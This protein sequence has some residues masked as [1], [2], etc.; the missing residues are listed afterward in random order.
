MI[1]Q[2]LL[3]PTTIHKENIHGKKEMINVGK[4][5]FLFGFKMLT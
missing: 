4:Q 1:I 5:T 2:F 3:Y